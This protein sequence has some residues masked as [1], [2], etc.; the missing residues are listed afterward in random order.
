MV[1]YTLVFTVECTLVFKVLSMFFLY[2]QTINMKDM[3]LWILNC[4]KFP[5]SG[6]PQFDVT[7][8]VVFILRP[9]QLTR[10]SVTQ[11]I[12]PSSRGTTLPKG[13]SAI[14]M[15]L[16]KNTTFLYHRS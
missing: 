8:S 12:V 15:V 3:S 11:N 7:R 14:C 16:M 1:I 5:F 2:V 13:G 4:A 9:F 10:K 6:V